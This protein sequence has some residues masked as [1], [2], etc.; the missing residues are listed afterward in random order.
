MRRRS[1]AALMVGICVC[2]LAWP[3]HGQERASLVYAGEGVPVESLGGVRQTLSIFR[4]GGFRELGEPRLNV[5]LGV[6]YEFDT[7]QELLH[8]SRHIGVKSL[9]TSEGDQ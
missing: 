8:L 5:R 1:V 7:T 6:Q 4:D 3:V 9:I 2:T